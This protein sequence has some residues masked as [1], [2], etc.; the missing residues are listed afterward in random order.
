M[1]LCRTNDK[2]IV[3]FTPVQ[4]TYICIIHLNLRFNKGVFFCGHVICQLKI[5]RGSNPV[6]PQGPH[7]ES[8]QPTLQPDVDQQHIDNQHNHSHHSA[9][10]SP[11]TTGSITAN[12]SPKCTITVD[13]DTAAVFAKQ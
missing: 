10:L 9:T 5:W 4:C 11:T 3:F 12:K 13:I 1:F 6:H 8:T 7:K 2:A